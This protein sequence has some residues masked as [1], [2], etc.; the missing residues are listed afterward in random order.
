MMAAVDSTVGRIHAHLASIGAGALTLCK[1]AYFERRLRSRWRACGVVDLESYADLLDRDAA[2]RSRLAAALTINVT[3]F[4]RNPTAWAALGRALVWPA[5]RPLMAWSAGCAT[6]EEAWSLAALLWR[7]RP[8]PG[9][10]Q[11][12][13][14][15]LDAPS[16][17]VALRGRYPLAVRAA[18][19]AVVPEAPLVV[20]ADGVSMPEAWRSRLRFRQADLTRP[21]A[22][23]GADL[24]LCRNVLIYFA[25]AAQDAILTSL[26]DALHPG[27]LLML[28]KAE[29]AA[30]AVLPRLETVDRRE[31]IYR[32]V[33]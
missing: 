27:G 6:G 7:Q 12:E 17:A 3:G 5:D 2:E 4:F 18:V 25:E 29:L 31:R 9:A 13:A 32:R 14:T 1:P 23:S 24:I 20:D 11:V 15:D 8:E 33:R 22:T 16:L 10:W 19:A 21:G 28:G 30:W 26:V